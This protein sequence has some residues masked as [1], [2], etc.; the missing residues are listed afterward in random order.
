MIFLENGK[1][2]TNK[3]VFLFD[4]KGDKV[5]T[6]DIIFCRNEKTADELYELYIGKGYSV[7]VSTV[8]IESGTH[9]LHTVKRL[10][11]IED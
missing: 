7:M 3:I 5:M 8:Q 11:I 2:R 4:E 9:G 6:T 10:D 1:S